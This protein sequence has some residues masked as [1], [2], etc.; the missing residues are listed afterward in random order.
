[1]LRAMMCSLWEAR[2]PHL[3][4]ATLI[5]G[6]APLPKLLG[7]VLRAEGVQTIKLFQT[8]QTPLL[9]TSSERGNSKLASLCQETDPTKQEEQGMGQI[10]YVLFQVGLPSKRPSQQSCR[11]WLLHTVLSSGALGT[12]LVAEEWRCP[13]HA[14]PMARS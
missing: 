2:C 8:A 7:S 12:D 1:M 10:P 13:L 3:Y 5:F 14:N 11:C 4:G 9:L 6:G